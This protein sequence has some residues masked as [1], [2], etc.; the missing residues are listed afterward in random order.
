M[1][2]IGP[3]KR[4]V[5]FF[6]GSK[7]VFEGTIDTSNRPFS[8]KDDASMKEWA[9]WGLTGM[10]MANWVRLGKP[11]SK[12]LTYPPGGQPIERITPYNGTLC[13]AKA[14]RSFDNFPQLLEEWFSIASSCR[15]QYNLV[16]GLDYS[17][18]ASAFVGAFTG[19]AKEPED[20][21][22]IEKRTE[23]VVSGPVPDQV[24]DSPASTEPVTV[25]GVT[26]PVQQAAQNNGTVSVLAG[27]QQQ[28]ADTENQQATLTTSGLEAAPGTESEAGFFSG[29]EFTDKQ[30]YGIPLWILAV[31]GTAF[32]LWKKG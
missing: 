24:P 20:T 25:P 9:L 11:I 12:R 14:E 17:E 26:D 4:T 6:D 27:T 21:A 1:A 29:L 30:I 32:V 28:L 2:V 31:A 10:N 5:Y 19:G 15:A 18:S 8:S 13:D 7:K 23:I 3:L 16:A 22:P